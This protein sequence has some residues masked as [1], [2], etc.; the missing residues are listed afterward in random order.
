MEADFNYFFRWDVDSEGGGGGGI[1]GVDGRL[2][3]R[4]RGRFFQLVM[5]VD[6]V[7]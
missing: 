7:R 1:I 6:P 5:P 3:S 2:A 4:Q